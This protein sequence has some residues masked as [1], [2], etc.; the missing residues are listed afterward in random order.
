MGLESPKYALPGLKW[1]GLRSGWLVDVESQHMQRLSKRDQ[2]LLP[3]LKAS[4]HYKPRAVSAQGTAPASHDAAGRRRMAG[5]KRRAPGLDAA[6]SQ[7]QTQDPWDYLQTSQDTTQESAASESE[8]SEDTDSEDQGDEDEGSRDPWL[9]ELEVMEAM[10][11][12]AD[13]ESVYSVVG[14]GGLKDMV[15]SSICKGDYI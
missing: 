7:D 12:K 8:S 10:G 4:L 6:D 1:L 11:Y 14:Y 2:S 3:G 9:G 15:V 13:I 5:H